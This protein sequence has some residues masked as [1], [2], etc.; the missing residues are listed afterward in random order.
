M[1]DIAQNGQGEKFT[2]KATVGK[3]AMRMMRQVKIKVM[4]SWLALALTCGVSTVQAEDQIVVWQF[5]DVQSGIQEA[6]ASTVDSHGNLIITGYTDT[7]GNDDFY[8]IKISS[9]DHTVLWAARYEHQGDDWAV[10]VAVDGNDDVIVTGFIDNG[11][12]TDIGVIKY[13]GA[14]GAPVWTSPYLFNGAANGNDYPMA[15]AVDHQNNIFVAGYTNSGVSTGDDGIVF[16]LGPAGGNPDGT[17]LWHAHY[18]GAAH[19]NDRFNG[20]SVGASGIAVAGYSTVMHSGNR[21]DYDYLTMKFDAAGN[22]LWEK[23]YDDGAD[24]DQ[25]SSIGMDTAGNVIVTGEGIAGGQQNIVTIKYAATN[26]V[27]SWLTPYSVGTHNSAKGLLVD[28]D[29][30]VYLIGDSFTNSGKDD[31]YTARYSGAN[32]ARVWER[33]FDSGNNNSDVPM[34]LALDSTGGLYVTGHTHIDGT[35]DKDFQTL[36]YNKA[37]GNQIWQQGPPAGGSQ[38]PVGVAVALGVSADGN[39]YVGGW[40]WQSTNDVDYFA[41]KYKA[42]LLNAPT[43]LTATVV[44]ES[45]VDLSWQDNSTAPNEDNFCIER[46]QGFAC[47]DFAELTCGIGQDLTAYTDNSVNRDTWYSYRVRGKSGT[48]AYSLPSPQVAVLTTIIDYPAPDWLYIYN[49]IDGLDDQAL[50]I[51]AGSD[52]NPVATGQSSTSSSQYDYFTVKLNRGDASHPVWIGDYDDPDGQGDKGMCLAIDNNDDVVVSGFSSVNDGQGGNT[53]AIFTIKYAS[54]GPDQYT[55]YPLWA[56][57]YESPAGNRDAR[58][59]AVAAASDGSNFMVV[60]GHGR[61]AAGNDDIYLIKYK[62]NHDAANQQVWAITPFDGGYR[63]E[64]VAT[65]FTSTGDVVVVG[66]TYNA[67]GDSDIFISKYSGADGSKMSGWP[68][69]KNFG[70]GADAIKA[71]AVG[72]DD[73]IYVAGY[74]MNAAGNLDI[75][76]NKF[77]GNGAPLWGDGKI[78]DGPGHGFDEA[79]GIAID[80]NDGDIVVGATITSASGST[81]FHLLRY[82]ADGT[83]LW[84]KTLDQAAHDEVLVAMAMSPSGEICLAGETD[85]GAY[86]D[87][88]A[89]KYDHLGNLIGSTKFDHGFDDTVT[90]ITANHLGEFYIAGYSATGVS[91]QDDYD[92]VVFRLNGQNQLQAPSPFTATAYNTSVDLRWTEND[93]TGNGYKLYRKTGSCSAGGDTVFLQSD[94]VKT[95]SLGTETFTDSGLNIGSTYCYG[96]EVYRSTGEVSRITEHQIMTSIPVPPSNVVAR[97]DNTSDVEVCWHDNSASE[98][99]FKIERCAGVNCENFV[100]IATAPAELNGAAGST[101][102]MDTTACDSGAGS[103]FRYRVQAYKQNEWSSGFDGASATVTVTKLLKPTSLITRNV[104][105]TRVDL[106]WIDTTVDES[107]F[108]IERCQGTNCTNFAEVGAVSSVKGLDLYLDMN[109]STWTASPGA[110]IDYSSKGRHATAFGGPTTV[111]DSYGAYSGRSGSLNSYSQYLTAPLAVDQSAQSAGVTM[112]AWVKPTSTDGSYRYLFSTEDGTTS[113]V[114]NSWGLLRYASTWYVATGEGVRDTGVAVTPDQWQHL[115]VVFTPGVGIKVYKD[116]VLASTINYIAPHATSANFTIGRQGVLNQGFFYGSVDEVAVYNRGLTAAEIQKLKTV[117]VFPESTGWKWFWDSSVLANTAYTYQIKARKQTVCGATLSDPSLGVNATTTPL[118]PSPMTATRIEPGVVTLTWTPQ[119]TTQ[120]GFQ[121]ERCNGASCTDYS[122]VS[123]AIGATALKYTDR[124][125]CFGSA[126]TNRYRVK[127][128]G[129]WGESLPSS[130]ASVAS[131]AVVSPTSPAATATEASVKLTWNYDLNR[132]GFIVARCTG[133]QAV[134]DQSPANFT[135]VPNSPFSGQD[136][137]LQGLWRMDESSWT[138][139]AGEVVDSSGRGHHGTAINGAAVDSPGATMV[140]GYGGYGAASFDGTNDYISTDLMVDQSVATTPGATFMGWVYLTSNS[141]KRYLFS[142]DNDGTDWAL[143]TDG[144]YWKVDTGS[145]SYQMNAI[146]LNTWQHIALVFDPASGIKFYINSSLSSSTPTIDY[147]GSTAPFTIGRQSASLGNYF[148]GKIDEVRV[149]NRPLT[150]TEVGNYRNQTAAP[151]TVADTDP[152]LSLGR[153][154]TYKISRVAGSDCGDWQQTALAAEVVATTP[155]APSVPTNLVVTQKSTTELD[156]S[157]QANTSSETYSILERCQGTGCAFATYDTFQV[158]A[159]V[160][161]FKDTSVCE[162]QTYRYRVKT[163]KG[164]SAPWVWETG[165]NS[166]SPVEKS[167]VTANPVAAVNLTAVSESEIDVTWTDTN[168]DED[169]YELSRCRVE[170]GVTACDQAAQF[171]PLPLGNFPGT[172]SGAL[173]QYRMDETAWTGAA[174]EVKDASGTRHGTSYNASTV[175]EG[176]FGRAG[177]FNGSTSY[178]ST[179]LT[180][181]QGRNSAG[182]T[183][184]A[185][186]YP[187]ATDSIARHV[188]STENGGYDWSV[189]VQNGKWCVNTG[190]SLQCTAATGSVTPNTWQ[191]IAAVFTPLSGVKL[192][193]NGTII[194]STSEID[195]D[196]ST[197]A[198][199]IGRYAGNSNGAYYFNGRIDEVLVYGRPLTDAEITADSTYQENPASYFYQ[200]TSVQHSNTYYYKVTAKKAAGC[201]WAKET[202]ASKSTPAPPVPT[203]LVVVSSDTTSVTLRWDDNNGSETGYVVSRCDGTNGG[204]GSPV[205]VNRPAGAGTGSMTYQDTGLCQ[206]QTY[207]YRVWATGAWGVTAYAEKGM[208]TAAQPTPINLTANKVSEVEIDLTWDFVANDETGVKLQRCRGASCVDVILPP[209]TK[210]YADNELMPITE[211][212]YRVIVYK[213]ASC[214]WESAATEQVCA[215]TSLIDGALTA[216]PVDTT[217]VSLAWGD[218]TQ[219]ETTSTV[220]RCDGDLATCCNSNPASCSGSFTPVGV[221]SVNQ[222]AYTDTSA[223]AGSAYTY[224][225]NTKSEGLSGRN[226][227]CWTKRAPLTFTSF[228]AYSGVEVVIAYKTGMRADFADLRFYDATAHRE[229]QYWLKQKTDSSSATV[230]LMTGSNA[231]IYLYYGNPVATDGS[232]TE[233]LFTEVYDEF[234]GTTINPQKWVVIDPPTD[235]ISQN[236]G[237]KFVNRGNTLLDAAVFSTKTFERAAGNELYFDFTT[238]GDGSS[239]T[240]SF[241]LGWEQDQ[242]TS[243]AYSGNGAHLLQLAA[244]NYTTYYMQYVYEDFSTV[245]FPQTLYNDLTRYQVKIVLNGTSGVSHGAKYYIKG[246]TYPNWVLLQTT[247]THR[248][249]DDVLRIGFHQAYHDITI[250]QVTVKH[251]SAQRGASV[252]FAGAEG[253]GVTCL[254]FSYTWTGS[255]TSA[256]DALTYSALPPTG[257]TASVAEGKVALAWSARTNDESE[258]RVERN[259]GGGYAQIGS[260][261][262]KTTTYSDA[263]MPVST[264]C[265]Y[266][267]KGHKEVPCLWT[268]IPSNEVAIL[269]PPVGPVLAVS[270][271]NP[272]QLRLDWSD[273]ADE[274]GYDV[275]AQV[276]GGAWMPVATLPANQVTFTDNHGINPSTKYTYRVRARRATGNSAW[277]QNSATTPA[278]TPGAATCPLP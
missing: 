238:G 233:A 148:A 9:V 221:V 104:T 103:S 110:V 276:F 218:T 83:L 26:G 86:T 67:A 268:S 91:A 108:A 184:E 16:K 69:I 98:D 13:H 206:G 97:P 118:A 127:A 64:P 136:S 234:A 74:A 121:V 70:Y 236:N 87:V 117:G 6:Q 160:T 27:Q 227:G 152:L 275:E 14:T 18:D 52:N 168:Q 107:D 197:A 112:M 203:N 271:E 258:F 159:G 95:I 255:P 147:D 231:N 155:A 137:A 113:Q 142:T 199:E 33:V 114:K 250:N 135:P 179:P 111:A 264:A 151:I 173:L 257:L 94:L 132:S 256:D 36:K 56:A 181:D 42:D 183:M 144:S 80:P 66:V 176:R 124:S 89:V 99:G 44:N 126:G 226:N 265:S 267:V 193:K 131:V 214:S 249:S 115:A 73:S 239:M 22:L 20:I 178:V 198:F 205:L 31:F 72:P 213:T 122:I 244:G 153:T 76:V 220:E 63:D 177:S 261:T 65:A 254:T 262:G 68:Y 141:G 58:A 125:A 59:K 196:L 92:F 48:I 145:G 146:T 191:H 12:N 123:S 164:T 53:D 251:A 273:A 15:L 88:L 228:P 128:L 119:T 248:D 40:S 235:K 57:Q 150:S 166:P 232:S 101:C 81:D 187:I 270:P 45:R 158:G 274:E 41:V 169:G 207:T 215:T 242:T 212:C 116:G 209:G 229:L 247:S 154:Y 161:T 51:A 143:Y 23:T 278:Y 260:V 237:L 105:E 55:G 106:Q 102:F 29:D 165:Y 39:V 21:Q 4:M 246:G 46:C 172:T 19:G 54:T 201:G 263:T 2:G 38:Q 180:I 217:T 202:T 140:S 245:S 240:Q 189:I 100:E 85:N 185:W 170:S 93:A 32:G 96:V 182:V 47:N 11:V 8:T 230:W 134:C 30:D 17:P 175:A 277:G 77:S 120:T 24:N 156:L 25:A 90:A 224:R 162:G 133:T 211:Y 149:F 208:T 186:V 241:F 195:Y 130:A 1:K 34:A 71:L 37:N 163:V 272:F 200:D 223:C 84:Q 188:L 61:N 7:A 253:D 75:Y 60:T 49:D 174:A 194:L 50:A 138:G 10:A 109:E 192:Y 3:A 35:A 243:T 62:P 190:L 157:W 167:T 5:Q 78:I 43:G 129:P 171:S 210:S 79:V 252:N 225:V 259:C 216:D 204:C 219:T 266:R 82:Q 139:A 269:A 28:S 222:H